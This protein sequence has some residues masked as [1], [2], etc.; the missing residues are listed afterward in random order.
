MQTVQGFFSPASE[1]LKTWCATARPSGEVPAG[2]DGSAAITGGTSSSSSGRRMVQACAMVCISTRV[3]PTR[4][5]DRDLYVIGGSGGWQC[6]HSCECEQWPSPSS[7]AAPDFQMDSA[8][9]SEGQRSL[10]HALSIS[11]AAAEDGDTEPAVPPAD[12]DAGSAPPATHSTPSSPSVPN[13]H[14]QSTLPDVGFRAREGSGSV[15]QEAAAE[16]ADDAPRPPERVGAGEEA[17]N[18]YHVWGFREVFSGHK[19]RDAACPNSTG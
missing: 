10:P 2:R 1:L 18:E 13:P 19:V 5:S 4:M 8:P 6:G 12:A 16:G 9:Q 3:D 17:G 7:G 11:D 15:T 14:L